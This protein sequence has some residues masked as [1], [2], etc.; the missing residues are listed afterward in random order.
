V[1]RTINLH[2]LSLVSGFALAAVVFVSMSQV[3]VTGSSWGPPK[4][5][6]VNV[7]FDFSAQGGGWPTIPPNGSYVVYS[8]PSDRWLTVTGA[9]ANAQYCVWAEDLNG[10]V[11]PKGNATGYGA[12]TSDAPRRTPQECGGAV[13]WTFRPGSKVVLQTAGPDSTVPVCSL[14]GY[15]SRE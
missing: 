3:G 13:G 2:P 5:D 6:I 14:V 8:V 15:L 12:A 1:A 10:V 4:K 7:F 9:W 11:T